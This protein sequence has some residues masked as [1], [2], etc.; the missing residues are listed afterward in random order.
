MTWSAAFDEDVYRQYELRAEELVEELEAEIDA[1]FTPRQADFIADK[2]AESLEQYFVPEVFTLRYFLDLD[3]DDIY[4]AIDRAFDNVIAAE[5][6][7]IDPNDVNEVREQVKSMVDAFAIGR[8]LPA[9][10]D[11]LVWLVV[12]P[13]L[14][15]LVYWLSEAFFGRT[16]G[17]LIMGVRVMTAAGERAYVG[18]YLLRYFI[19]NLPLFLIVIGLFT[20]AVALF[21]VAGVASVVI[22]I[23]AMAMVGR[24]KRALHDLAANTAVYH[25]SGPVTW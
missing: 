8:I 21:P 5:R 2:L 4:L 22:L 7:D 23:G 15:F 9:V 16:L 1:R 10:V 18:T 25:T 3:E 24:E 11:F 13:V 12:A 17:K 14:V 20:R 6:A 19:K